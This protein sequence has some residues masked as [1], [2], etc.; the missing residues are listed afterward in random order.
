MA[1]NVIS[2]FAANVAHRNLTRSDAE[3]TDSLS[4]LSSGTRVVSAKDD[5]ASM[6][7]GS[8]LS[9]EI[10]ALRQAQVNAG[11][12]VSMLQVADGAM[13]RAHDILL[14]MKTLAVQAGSGQLSGTERGMLNTEYVQLVSEIDRLAFDTEFNGNQLVNGSIG[15]ATNTTGTA[16]DFE[17]ADGLQ[18]ISFIGAF[19]SSSNG[20]ISYDAA[21]ET[22]TVS[23]V[24]DGNSVATSF[25]G[26]ISSEIHDG[27]TMSTGTVVSL[28]SSGTSAKIDLLVNTLWDVDAAHATGTLGLSGAS[29]TNFTYKVG[30][31]TSP[32]ADEISVTLTSIS[33]AALGLDTT[34]VLDTTNSDAASL[35]ISSA[36]DALN[37][38][39]ADIGASQNRLEFA[40]AN[41]ATTLENTEAARSN[42]LDLDIAAEMSRLTSKQILVQAGV[43]MLAQ[44][45]QTP[46]TL[47]RLFQ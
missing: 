14:R 15:V 41:I 37:V 40:A 31:G 27:S 44:A 20:T 1:L 45:N 19:D 7:I 8:R 30:T 34:D 22:F 13:S 33:A 18:A 11:Q 36:V 38:A 21:S 16:P 6:A 42:L 28:T 2:N 43:A 24:E 26:G 3:M 47:L 39:R 46:E 35:A 9:A 10:N 12:A 32:T 17:P 23:A 4:K 5:A 29:T 25:T